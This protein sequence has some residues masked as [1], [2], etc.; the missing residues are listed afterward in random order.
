M[1]LISRSIRAD[2]A[3]NEAN[4]RPCVLR[5]AGPAGVDLGKVITLGISLS[6]FG[7]HRLT[8]SENAFQFVNQDPLILSDE[9]VAK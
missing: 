7:Y 8:L 3:R 2:I 6:R 9:P 5:L 4:L 1:V